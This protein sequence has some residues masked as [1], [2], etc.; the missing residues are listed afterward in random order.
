MHNDKIFTV[1]SMFIYFQT[2]IMG[3]ENNMKKSMKIA[4]ITIGVL[5]AANIIG[6]AIT[7]YK[8]G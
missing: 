6:L 4:S 3:G 2:Y 5:A 8:I 7:G 1:K